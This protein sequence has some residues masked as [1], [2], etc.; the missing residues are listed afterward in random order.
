MLVHRIR[1]RERESAADEAPQPLAQDVVEALDGAGL[2]FP[3]VGGPMAPFGQHLLVSPSRSL[4]SRP[5]RLRNISD[6]IKTES[7]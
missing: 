3:F 5:N 6:L 2:A 4:P 7:S 1:L